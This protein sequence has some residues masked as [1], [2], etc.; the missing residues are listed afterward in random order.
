MR[1]RGLG[2]P[3]RNA[4]ICGLVAVAGIIATWLGFREM[5]ALGRET[6]RTSAL[7]ALG[8]LAAILGTA[9]FVNFMRAVRVF[10]DMRS[11]RT[12]IERWTVPADEFARYREIDGRFAARGSQ[13]DYRPPRTVPPEGVEVIFADD[14]VL[15]GGRYFSLATTGIS[16]IRTVGFIASD[17]PM[18]EFATVLTT[19]T[20]MTSV[21]IHH[22]R[23][24]LRVPVAAKAAMPG[25]RVVNRYQD[26]LDRR[27]IVNPHFWTG[28]IK[29]GLITAAISA[30]AAAAGFALKER[31]QELSNVPL[32]LAVAGTICAIGGLLMA[33]MA[34]SLRRRQHYG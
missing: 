28:R 1:N 17:P 16:R 34:W 13:N 21:H 26:I 6:G 4:A 8:L 2:K 27:V 30:V 31:N 9:F 22:N 3:E 5:S 15:I 29:G 33:L 10:R 7:V 25:H 20:N 14:G 11:G 24:R 18:I 23:G 32:M 12:A 19:V